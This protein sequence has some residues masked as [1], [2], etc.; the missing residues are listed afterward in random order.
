VNEFL[1]LFPTGEM[2]EFRELLSHQ[3][4]IHQ[5]K[6]YSKA[7]TGLRLC[8]V[9]TFISATLR[10]AAR[11]LNAAYALLGWPPKSTGGQMEEKYFLS[12]SALPSPVA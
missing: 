1:F 3:K 8:Q 9:L 4:G 2:N 7:K 11:G 5:S 12:H 6:L 10:A